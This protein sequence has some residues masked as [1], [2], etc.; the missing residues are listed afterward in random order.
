MFVLEVTSGP[1][2]GQAIALEKG[3]SLVIGRAPACN[4]VFDDEELSGAHAEVTWND[5][6]FGV[7]DLLSR[8]GTFVN[9]VK[10]EGKK[11][12]RLGDFIQV[13]AVILQLKEAAPGMEVTRVTRDPRSDTG[14]LAFEAAET[15]VM[16][17]RIPSEISGDA[18]ARPGVAPMPGANRTLMAE[19][20]RGSVS[21]E[22]VHAAADLARMVSAEARG[23]AKVIVRLG[24]RV[25]PFKTLP[26][27][28]GR[29]AGS[30][31][32]LDDPAASLRHAVIDVRD[33]RFVVRDVGSSNGTFV[34]GQRVVVRALDNGDVVSIGA[35]KMLVVSGPYCL[36][37]EVQPPD[38]AGEAEQG[39]GHASFG[40]LARPLAQPDTGKKR[41]KKAA[42][43][44]WFATSDLDRGG[45]RA[46]SAA[47]AFLIGIL[48]VGWL[49]SSGSSRVLAGGA[50]MDDH[51]SENFALQ[52][53]AFGRASCTACHIGVGKVSSLKCFDC[54]QNNRPANY[55]VEAKL[56]CGGCHREHRGATF[57]SA[58]GALMGCKECHENP[59][60]NLRRTKPKL[61][62]EF[63]P[64]AP[65]GDEFHLA[66]HVEREIGCLTCHGAEA[67]ASPKG[68][69]GTCGQ[70]HAPDVVQ[71]GECKQCHKEHPDREV[72]VAV[73]ATGEAMPPRFDYGSLLW[74]FGLIVAPLLIAAMMPRRRARATVEEPAPRS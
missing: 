20:P 71:A 50:L 52:A 43:L 12:L 44:I 54:H 55:H 69:R 49:L 3:K 19:V 53:T 13:G 65:A 28:I 47:I 16:R 51:E 38:A 10:I 42:D 5:S 30:G 26:V 67:A 66:H 27:T 11:N 31:V 58:S 72:D 33:D 9:G 57:A 6:G 34:N 48:F 21:A 61:V 68:A 18:P 2:K 15:R 62:A 59:H 25:D 45:F 56:G 39:A 14:I 8:N 40:L 36:G 4:L 74:V 29:E 1:T 64:D 41:K 24:E 60:E 7:Q 63:K 70:C 46:R 22:H 37:L 73:A 23:G 17:R 32:F 35:H